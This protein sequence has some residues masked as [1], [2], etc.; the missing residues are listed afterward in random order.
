MQDKSRLN[1]NQPPYKIEEHFN[2]NQNFHGQDFDLTGCAPTK[3]QQDQV[4]DSNLKHRQ[5]VIEQYKKLRQD[6]QKSVKDR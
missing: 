1:F 2:R 3:T 4:L 5:N 6:N